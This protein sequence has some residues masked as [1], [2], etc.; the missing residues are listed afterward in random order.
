MLTILLFI[1]I[2]ESVSETIC[3]GM[4]YVKGV[5]SKPVLKLSKELQELQ[6]DL[7][8]TDEG[9][10]VGFQYHGDEEDFYDDDDD[11]FDDKKKSKSK[12]GF[13]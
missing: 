2:V 1:P 13:N 4:E 10:A 8:K 6:T 11:Y 12:C 3:T 5:V 7:K 9:F